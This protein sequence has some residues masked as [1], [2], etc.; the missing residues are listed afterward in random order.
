MDIVKNAINEWLFELGQG[1]YEVFWAIPN[2]IWKFFLKLTLSVI[3]LDPQYLGQEGSVWGSLQA[4]E[5]YTTILSIG[6]SLLAL[7]FLIGYIRQTMNF[8][9]MASVE[10][11]LRFAIKFVIATLLMT[12]IIPIMFEITGVTT[13]LV[14]QIEG[15]SNLNISVEKGSISLTNYQLFGILTIVSIIAA[16]VCG[17][18]IFL[19]VFKRFINIY[20]LLLMAPIAMSTLAGDETISSSGVAWIKTTLGCIF[21]VVVIA[22]VIA[23]AGTLFSKG[24]MV[25]GESLSSIFPSLDGIAIAIVE[26]TT[27][28]VCTAGAV[29]GAEEFL[30]RSFAL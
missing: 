26:S 29:A 6:A 22:L 2:G 9:E 30:K 13:I 14:K 15:I 7:F 25:T 16:F 20:V 23:V 21:E 11:F 24:I 19:S 18:K 27:M 1:F 17:V 12:N 5:V 3:S 28:M 4:T 10:N 8:K